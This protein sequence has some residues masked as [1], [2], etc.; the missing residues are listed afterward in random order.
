MSY[1]LGIIPLCHRYGEN[2]C[3]V[4]VQNLIIFVV[5][6]RAAWSNTRFS[7]NFFFFYFLFKKRRI[8]FSLLYVHILACDEDVVQN[9]QLIDSIKCQMYLLVVGVSLA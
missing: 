8:D 4:Y 5:K 6:V 1:F 3:E 2:L 9:Y 7:A